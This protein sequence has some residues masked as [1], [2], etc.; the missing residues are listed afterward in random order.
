MADEAFT[1]IGLKVF[2]QQPELDHELHSSRNSAFGL[3]Y[4]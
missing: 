1:T 4:R 2:E 3:L